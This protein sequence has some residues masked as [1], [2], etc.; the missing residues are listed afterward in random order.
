MKTIRRLRVLVLFAFPPSLW[1]QEGPHSVIEFWS[2][3]ERMST[4]TPSFLVAARLPEGAS[5][6]LVNG[7]ELEFDS[8]GLDAHLFVDLQE[9]ENELCLTVETAEGD[10]RTVVKNVYYDPGYSTV[11]INRLVYVNAAHGV[12]SDGFR[13]E[14]PGVIVIDPEGDRVLGVIRGTWVA[15]VT[16]S[17]DEIITNTGERYSTESHSSTGKHLPGYQFGQRLVFSYDGTVVYFGSSKVDLATNTVV[18]SL[19]V[20]LG[21]YADITSDDKQLVLAGGVV[22]VES[23]IFTPLDFL[24][25]SRSLTGDLAVEPIRGRVW[26]TS[27]AFATG[28][29][30]VLSL[31]D[32]APIAQFLTGDYAGDI[33]FHAGSARIGR[34]GNTY[35]G[36]GGIDTIHLGRLHRNGLTALHGAQSLAASVDGTVY[37]TAAK[38]LRDGR[39]RGEDWIR[40]V[41]ELRPIAD[42]PELVVSKTFFASLRDTIDEPYLR[43]RSVFIA[44][45]RRP[46]FRRGNLDGSESINLSHA[47]QILGYLYLGG[48]TPSCL[49]AADVDDSGVVN[50]SDAVHLLNYLFRGGPEPP[51]PGTAVCG[52]DTTVDE[53]DCR[54]KTCAA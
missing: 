49:D 52:E 2:L 19:P 28:Q 31:E 34:F 23:L 37:A 36:G 32:G 30:D 4:N 11:S 29:I 51:A 50:L 47:V 48:G 22:D 26:V 54:V 5:R 40:G 33:S 25:E 16:R 46:V 13:F 27:Y 17:G 12:L 44:E 8:V 3:P 20:D 53:L 43:P 38:S 42:G 21:T 6:V 15:G 10:H 18:E 9:G 35:F 39:I 7:A 41:V 14:E 1:S 24:K 45:R